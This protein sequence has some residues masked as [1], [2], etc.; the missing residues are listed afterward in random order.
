MSEDELSAG[1]DASKQCRICLDNDDLNDIISPCLCSGGSA[2][3]HRKCLNNWRSENAN[4]KAFK[5]CDV[6]QFEYIIETIVSDPKAERE[7]LLKYHYFVIRDLSLITLALQSV[8]FAFAFLL[9]RIDRN[10]GNIK[11]VFPAFINGFL[12]YYLSG[13]ILLLVILGIIAFIFLGYVYITRGNTNSNN[14]RSTSSTSSRGSSN[15][16][17]TVAGTMIAMIIICA[18]VGLFVGIILS[19]IILRKIMK[20]HNSKLWLRQEAEKYIV[21][22]FTGRRRDLEKYTRSNRNSPET[23]SLLTGNDS[24]QN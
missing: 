2:Y 10:S 18:V 1:H 9:K 6:C 20:N 15:N 24:A 3:V 12:V 11:N 5:F 17:N 23:L 22:D 21:K 19:V 4:G 14:R 16:A 7:R 8:I 13:F